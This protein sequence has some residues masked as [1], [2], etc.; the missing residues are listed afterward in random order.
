MIAHDSRGVPENARTLS[1]AVTRRVREAIEARWL[2]KSDADIDRTT[3]A[4]AGALDEAAAEAHERSLHPEELV[5]AIKALED[6]AAVA[7]GIRAYADRRTLR[8][9]L[10]TACIHAYFRP[11]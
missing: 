9:R 10:V 1:E 8:A 3:N 6:Q 7:G 11:R 5:L 2:A 4:L